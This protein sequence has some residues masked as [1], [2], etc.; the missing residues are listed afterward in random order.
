M[1]DIGTVHC[2]WL[3][4]WIEILNKTNSKILLPRVRIELTTFRWLC[5]IMRLTRYLLR[6]RG[7]YLDAIDNASFNQIAYWKLLICVTKRRVRV[8][9]GGFIMSYIFIFVLKT[10]NLTPNTCLRK[11][12]E[13]ITI[14]VSKHIGFSGALPVH[15]ITCSLISVKILKE[16][17]MI[18]LKSNWTP[19]LVVT[20]STSRSMG[21]GRTLC[22]PP[23]IAADLWFVMPRTLNFLNVFSLVSL[24]IQFKPNSNWNMAETY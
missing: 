5:L 6:Y 12:V 18:D 17:K 22:P 24:A 1:I 8:N 10:N 4:P 16:K 9:V 15:A 23:L 19:E 14:K 20:Y 13:L 11:V 3:L 2:K 7:T 21:G